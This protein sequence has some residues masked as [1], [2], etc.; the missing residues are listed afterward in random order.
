MGTFVKDRNFINYYVEGVEKPY[1]FDIN[2][3]TLYGI[4]GT[5]IKSTP[6]G[7]G[8]ALD[9][10]GRLD[11]PSNALYIMGYLRKYKYPSVSFANMSQYTNLF[12]VADKLESIGYRLN[13]YWRIRE[14]EL[15]FVG[16]NFKKF[17][18]AF[19]E[20]HELTIEEFM[21]SCGFEIWCKENGLN[22]DNAHLPIELKEA[23]YDYRDTFTKE[24]IPYVIYFLQ[25]GLWCFMK[26]NQHF[27][28]NHL[29]EFFSKAEKIGHKVEKADFL[30]QYEVVVNTYETNKKK[31]QADSIK[32]NLAKHK[33]TWN[34]ETEHL[35]IV[36]PQ[37]T[38]DFKKEADYQ[39]NCV[40]NMYMER[41]IEGTTNVIFIRHKNDIDTPYITCEV[42]NKGQ[43]VQYLTRYNHRVEDEIG[44]D[45]LKRFIGHIS[46]TW[47]M[48]E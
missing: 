44:Q 3:A 19:R 11:N 38:E 24:Q 33:A 42:N 13:S 28:F 18:Q 22:F 48:G 14:N 10:I 15:A 21:R 20:D 36:V 34:F 27:L 41:V 2:T 23:L 6:K 31:Y 32:K 17:A 40:Y 39:S 5:A 4:K 26:D 46:N 30:R 1:K 12:Q 25:R 8:K 7:L 16:D 37:S 47:E 29:R 43:V 9:N 35:A 45:F